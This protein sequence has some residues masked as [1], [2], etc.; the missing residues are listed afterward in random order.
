M[1]TQSHKKLLFLCTGNYYRSRFSEHFFNQLAEKKE[2]QWRA[3]SRGLAIEW[4]TGSLRAISPHAIKGLQQ[5]GLTMSNDERFPIQA[6]DTDFTTADKIIALDKHEHHPIMEK[7]FPRWANAIE[8][9]IVHDIDKTYPPLAL[10]QIEQNLCQLIDSLINRYTI[11]DYR[12]IQ[13]N[14]ILN[15]RSLPSL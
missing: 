8:Y 14:S 10:R 9:W 11:P 5:R 12:I 13:K 6:V 2:L 15:F 7:R 1:N 4:G 3:D